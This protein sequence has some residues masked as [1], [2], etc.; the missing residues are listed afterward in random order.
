MLAG[1]R[2]SVAD[3]ERGAWVEQRV[4]IS[5]LVLALAEVVYCRFNEHDLPNVIVIVNVQYGRLI[6]FILYYVR[7]YTQAHTLRHVIRPD[8][9]YGCV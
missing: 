3:R 9:L 6:T 8:Q 4:L 1:L 5:R 7:R 2:Q